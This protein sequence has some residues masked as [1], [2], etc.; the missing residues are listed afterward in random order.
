MS[1]LVYKTRCSLETHNS[2]FL[3]F[4]RSNLFYNFD[5]TLG[6]GSPQSRTS[7]PGLGSPNK[8]G[9]RRPSDGYCESPARFGSSPSGYNSPRDIS[10]GSQARGSPSTSGTSTPVQSATQ[11]SFTQEYNEIP[12]TSI[13]TDDNGVSNKSST[14]P[15][16]SKAAKSRS[17][18]SPE[19]PPP[20]SRVRQ[21]GI[22]SVPPSSVRTPKCTKPWVKSQPG[23]PISM[24]NGDTA[25]NIKPVFYGNTKAPYVGVKAGNKIATSTSTGGAVNSNFGQTSSVDT[26]LS[27]VRILTY[28]LCLLLVFFH[29]FSFF[30]TVYFPGC[31]YIYV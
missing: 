2:I 6:L 12:S 7:S 30:R 28:C 21:F 3:L 5:R 25:G 9:S 17:T 29:S 4:L 23:K 16:R 10:R 13:S 24:S 8:F 18:T 15:S 27:V 31:L 1:V 22:R 19:L 20:R 26:N 14:G 11:S